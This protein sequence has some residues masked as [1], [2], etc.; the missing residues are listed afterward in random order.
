MPVPNANHRHVKVSWE[1]VEM[2]RHAQIH[3]ACTARMA[4]NKESATTDR[5]TQ[6]PGQHPSH[7]PVKVRG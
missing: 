5:L 1:K 3:R 6:P 2:D 4:E 7:P